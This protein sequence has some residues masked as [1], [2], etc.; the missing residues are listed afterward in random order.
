ML[1]VAV[2]VVGAAVGAVVVEVTQP[3]GA[4][5][6][7]TRGA[8][9]TTA[10]SSANTRSSDRVEPGP[11]RADRNETR[12]LTPGA[13][14]SFAIRQR[15]LDGSVGLAA[16][17][18]GSG[19]TATFGDVH[20][21]HAWSTSKVPVLVTLLRD[22]ERRRSALS[23]G[24]RADAALAIE[25]SDNAAIDALFSHLEAL[26]GG[27]IPASLAIQGLLRAAGDRRTI[28]N[29]APNAYGFTTEGQTEWSVG[30]EV[31]FYRA[32]ARGCLLDPRDTGY[33]LG[34]MRKVVPSQRWG[35]GAAGYPTTVPLAF[36]GGWGPD[37]AGDYQVRQTAVVGSGANGYVV[38]MLALPAS[39]S[40]TDG[41]RMVS[42]LATWARRHLLL[43]VRSEP[44]TCHG[45]R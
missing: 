2:F 27:L 14:A 37:A 7:V 30:G 1:A 9:L 17:A 8:R 11:I 18:L 39:G 3:R 22:D 40:F 33:V 29:T 5:R 12:L 45:T 43:G 15:R 6:V 38:S 31:A 16:A 25:Q 19:Q 10:V 23:E 44:Q 21:A 41:V 13:S 36:K 32:L 28:V 26:R 34:L 20:V 42:A 24:E 35:A 4:T